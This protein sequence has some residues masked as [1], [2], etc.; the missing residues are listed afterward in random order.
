MSGKKRTFGPFLANHLHYKW[1]PQIVR[2]NIE[3]DPAPL[4]L[5]TVERFK[6]NKN[7]KQK[8]KQND[9]PFQIN[10]IRLLCLKER[11][12]ETP[13]KEG[14]TSKPPNAFIQNKA[15]NSNEV[16]YDKLILQSYPLDV[17]WECF[18]RVKTGQVQTLRG[19][20]LGKKRILW[21]W[22]S[23]G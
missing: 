18:L 1:D 16:P 10:D 15:L 9:F 4:F 21:N 2:R 12:Y 6:K 3:G 19:H 23:V 20:K 5:N 17:A 13:N 8:S 22:F 7:K 11:K 14:K